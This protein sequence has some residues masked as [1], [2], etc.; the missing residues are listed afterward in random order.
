M[1]FYKTSNGQKSLKEL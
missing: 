1:A